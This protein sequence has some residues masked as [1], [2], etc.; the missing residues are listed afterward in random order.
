MFPTSGTTGLS[1][2]RSVE[3]IQDRCQ[4]ALSD[5]IRSQYPSD[6]RRFGKLLLLLTTLRRV[7]G[8][9]IQGMLFES[10]IGDVPVESLICDMIKD[11]WTENR[12][13]FGW[14]FVW[15]SSHYRTA[16]SHGENVCEATSKT[17]NSDRSQMKCCLERKASMENSR[18][19]QILC[20]AKDVGVRASDLS[21]FDKDSIFGSL[22][23][24][25]LNLIGWEALD[26]WL[27]VLK[28]DWTGDYNCWVSLVGNCWPK[29]RSDVTNTQY[30]LE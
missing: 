4:T 29:S 5:Y 6:A 15:E 18:N 3:V 24:C 22:P 12:L 21:A 9:Y 20:S 26:V 28:F 16:Q 14:Y 19:R 2:P 8:K 17:E 7:N 30:V 1:D 11:I 10:T 27:V 25:M 13:S 23:R